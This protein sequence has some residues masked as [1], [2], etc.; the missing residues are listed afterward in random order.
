MIKPRK[1]QLRLLQGS[2][3]HCCFLAAM[4]SVMS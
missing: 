3:G 1:V 2:I 4:A